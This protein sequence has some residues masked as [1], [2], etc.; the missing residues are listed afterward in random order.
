MLKKEIEFIK[1]DPEISGALFCLAIAISIGVG[2]LTKPA[3]YV[4]EMEPRSI[5]IPEPPPEWLEDS[6][7]RDRLYVASMRLAYWANPRIRYSRAVRKKI[8]G[9]VVHCNYPCGGKSCDPPPSAKRA[10]SLVQYLH[11]GDRRRGGRFGYHFY[12]S[13]EGKVLQGAPLSQATNHIKGPRSPKRKPD[14]PKYFSNASTIG[15]SIVGACDPSYGRNREHIT[16]WALEAAL[17]TVK[18][19]QK[20]FEL[21]CDAIRGHGEMQS[22][23]WSVEGVTVARIVRNS[24]GDWTG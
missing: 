2:L 17:K 10:L 13:Q 20:R 6:K 11:N 4:E 5:E 1:S 14:A 23:R 8:R 21:P 18:A 15:I 16:S 22:D 19:V 9:I 12:I 7:P 24:C 3:P